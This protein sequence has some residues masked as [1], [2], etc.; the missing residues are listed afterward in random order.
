M[1]RRGSPG[2]GGPLKGPLPR[3]Q[4]SV[5]Y[6]G[7]PGMGVDEDRAVAAESLIPCPGVGMGTGIPWTLEPSLRLPVSSPPC[8]GP[9][10][11]SQALQESERVPRARVRKEKEEER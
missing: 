3:I 11:L 9:H 6:L 4:E 8:Y 7:S 5:E 10:R 1:R 2:G